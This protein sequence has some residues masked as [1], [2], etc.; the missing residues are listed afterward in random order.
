MKYHNVYMYDKINNNMIYVTQ[1]DDIRVSILIF[2]ERESMIKLSVPELEE[3]LILNNII[4]GEPET[5][6][7]LYG[8]HTITDEQL[9]FLKKRIYK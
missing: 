1:H 5:M 8:K 7:L 3:E 9:L 2:N 4:I 6:R